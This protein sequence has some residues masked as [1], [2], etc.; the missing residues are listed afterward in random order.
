M[1]L[2]SEM[3]GSSLPQR[4]IDV[5]V[6]VLR[7]NEGKEVRNTPCLKIMEHTSKVN[8]YEQVAMCGFPSGNNAW[9][10]SKMVLALRL[11]PV[12]QF[13]IIAG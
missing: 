3:Q 12:M 8:L 6:A 2:A 13:G 9:N 11:S 10:V 7:P 5:D 1:G 4:G